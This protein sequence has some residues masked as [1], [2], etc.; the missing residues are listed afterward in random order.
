MR[1]ATTSV[2]SPATSTADTDRDGRW[3]CGTDLGPHAGPDSRLSVLADI[4]NP[5]G[6]IH[7]SLPLWTVDVTSDPATPSGN[8]NSDH[9]HLSEGIPRYWEAKVL[10]DI[11]GTHS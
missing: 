5:D 4:G 11:N 10:A 9:P 1:N 8:A 2:I 7:R 6:A 3:T